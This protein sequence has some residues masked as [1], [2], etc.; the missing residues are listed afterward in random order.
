MLKQLGSA[1]LSDD[2]PRSRW[3]SLLLALIALYLITVPFL[4]PG[5]RMMNVAVTIVVFVVL[6]GSFDLLLGY[7][8]M[9]SFAHA[10]F[11]GI[12]AYGVGIAFH[13]KGPNWAA[14]GMGIGA[15]M[16]VSLTLAVLLGLISLRVK[17]IFYAMTTMAA[18]SAFGAVVL[19]WSDLTGGD[20][21]RSFR[22][23]ELLMPGMRQLEIAGFAVS[24]NG[25]TLSYFL[26]IAACTFLFLLML[27][28]VNSRFGR[29][30]QAMRENEFRAEAIGYRTLIYRLA[31]SI[32][33]ALLATTAGV[34]MALWMRYVGPQTSVGFNVMLNILLM[35]VIGGLGTVYGA[36]LGVV[37]FVAAENYLQSLLAVTAPHA[38]GIPVLNHFLEPDRWM[39]WFGGLFVLAVYFFP[40]GLVGRLREWA[41]RRRRTAPMHVS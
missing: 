19:R 4:M 1:V 10:M 23:P 32:I 41:S 2:L 33:A 8:G 3:L 5:A 18:A 16:G 37:I 17:T 28:I 12:G 24:F 36:V 25:R 7:A 35:A 38:S 34:L 14:L 30:L 11:Y 15:A 20:D 31:V 26:I 9:V 21:G 22:V 39:L 27:R 40:N 29:V 13:L 6:V